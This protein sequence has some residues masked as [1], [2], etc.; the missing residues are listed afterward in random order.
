VDGLRQHARVPDAQALSEDLQKFF[1]RMFLPSPPERTEVPLRLKG[2]PRYGDRTFRLYLMGRGV[3]DAL[4][5]SQ[6]VSCLVAYQEEH[7]DL[8]LG[9]VSLD[10]MQSQNVVTVVLSKSGA[11]EKPAIKVAS[12]E[13]ARFYGYAA[14]KANSLKGKTLADLLDVLRRY[15]NP[16]DY[17][18]FMRDQERVSRDYASYGRA[19]AQVPIKFNNRHPDDGFRNKEYYPIISHSIIEK[20]AGADEAYVHVLYVN[21]PLLLENLPRGVQRTS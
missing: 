1:Q 2:H 9:R 10:T 3:V 4:E 16:E 12:S 8:D 5:T 18:Q 14:D 11:N 17:D 13:A 15:M 6:F 20:S 21:L 19:W 7:V